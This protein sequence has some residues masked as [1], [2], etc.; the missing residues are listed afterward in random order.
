MGL[1][2]DIRSVKTLHLP[3]Q[4]LQHWRDALPDLLNTCPVGRLDLHCGDWAL[5]CSD[6]R[7][8]QRILED[9]GRQIHRLMATV[10]ETVVSAAAIGLD[11]RLCEAGSSD[12]DKPSPPPGSLTVHQGT[13]RSGDH[14]QSDG[15]LLVVGDVN[16]GARISAAGDVLVWGRLRGVA[17]AGR[18]GATSSRIVSLH[19]RPLQLRIADVVARGPED[20]PIAGMA[21]Q[22][23]LVDGEIVIEPAQP[24]AL[25][26]S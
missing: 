19:L 15:S 6:L 23:R 7:D 26:R 1:T 9:S 18:D 24:Q 5:T 22:G 8:L 11:G 21:E 25:T 2:L 12:E 3:D 10:A 20:Q 16:P 14:L 17:H 4:R 13:L